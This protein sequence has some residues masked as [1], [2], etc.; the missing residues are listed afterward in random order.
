LNFVP[1][2]DPLPSESQYALDRKY[3]S[4]I[5]TGSLKKYWRLLSE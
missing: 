1:I 2:S 4:G 3:F 5:G